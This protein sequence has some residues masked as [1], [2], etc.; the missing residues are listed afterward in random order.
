MNP[1]L[2]SRVLQGDEEAIALFGEADHCA[3]ID[4]HDGPAEIV[5]AIAAFLPEGHLSLGRVTPTSCELVV[6][7][8]PG[9]SVPLSAKATQENLL[10][11]IDQAIRPAYELRQF[12]PC[13]GDG[14]SMF[15]A[16]ASVWSE[17]ERTR[18]EATE[19]LFLS[20]RR[21]AAYWSKPYLAR[22]FSKP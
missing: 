7:G 5:A 13:D 8:K 11:G 2:L 10:L 18:P 16:P 19:R 9:V 15:V 22:M 17:I 20:A 4:W 6:S 21:L 3:V 14:Y 1:S 12:R